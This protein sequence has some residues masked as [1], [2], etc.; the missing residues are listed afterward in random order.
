MKKIRY[1]IL[2]IA[3]FLTC[4]TNAYAACTQE[5][6]NGFKKVEDEYTVK[7]E[8]DKETKKYYI[9]FE[10]PQQNVYDFAIY[11]GN[12][13][14]CEDVS[15]TLSKCYH[16]DSGEYKIAIMGQTES[17]NDIFKTITLK[18]PKY[19]AYSEDPLCEGIEDFVLCN[20]TYEKEIDYDTFVSRIETYKKNHVENK[21]EKEEPT[22]DEQKKQNET[23]TKIL[24]YA[25]DNWLQI[26]IIVVFIILVIITIIVTAKSVRKSRRLE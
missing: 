13:F 16:F 15:D 17:C 6:I 7:Y 26:T 20:P 4:L 5:E 10:R 11:T 18:L 14:K 8:I 22:D 23:L 25:E 12:K 1:I 24:K 19:N 21:I 9:Y 2:T 3:I